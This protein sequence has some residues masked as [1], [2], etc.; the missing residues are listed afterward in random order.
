MFDCCADEL[1]FVRAALFAALTGG[2]RAAS[3]SAASAELLALLLPPG[4]S[5]RGAA[6]DARV[7]AL[8]AQ[9]AATQRPFRPAQLGG[10][11][12]QV[13]HTAGA[14]GWKPLAPGGAVAAQDFDAATCR[15]VNAV[16]LPTPL[17]TLRLTAEGD[18]SALPD[19]QPSKSTPARFAACILK[20]TLAVGTLRLP[21]P[22]AGEGSF[23]VAY[24]DQRLRVF[25][26]STGLAVQ[27]P[28]AAV[29][30]AA[31]RTSSAEKRGAS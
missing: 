17:G 8:L 10:G 16:T 24:V 30:A 13:V 19:G 6:G 20:G 1:I 2:S 14:L 21:L 23:E 22:I 7:A 12:W 29:Q 9:L 5:T 4:P 3:T 15:V 18:F 25:R 11:P 27:V 28:Q 26:S 31:L